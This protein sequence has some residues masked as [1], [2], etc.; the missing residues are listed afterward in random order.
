MPSNKKKK[1]GARTIDAKIRKAERRG[2]PGVFDSL[3]SF[4]GPETAE[5][6]VERVIGYEIVSTERDDVP[7]RV[8]RGEDGTI[9][10]QEVLT[11]KIVPITSKLYPNWRG[12]ASFPVARDIIERVRADCEGSLVRRVQKCIKDVPEE[13]LGIFSKFVERGDN[14]HVTCEKF[15]GVLVG[16]R[17]IGGLHS[18]KYKL[19][20]VGK[21][22]DREAFNLYAR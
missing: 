13:Q 16:G 10:L 15:D 4:P 9:F 17:H 1:G 7:C 19:T 18:Y 2:G 11:G 20:L 5:D 6:A 21:D 8:R 12:G 22:Y 14:I 3:P